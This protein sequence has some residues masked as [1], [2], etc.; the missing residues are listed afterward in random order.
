MTTTTR[1]LLDRLALLTRRLALVRPGSMA[2]AHLTHRIADVQEELGM[3]AT[4][5]GGR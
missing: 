5:E 1:A 3:L 2:H 4:A